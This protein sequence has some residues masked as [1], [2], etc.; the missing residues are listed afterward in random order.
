MRPVCIVTKH[1]SFTRIRSLH[2]PLANALRTRASLC[3]IVSLVAEEPEPDVM[4]RPPRDPKTALLDKFIAWRTFYVTIL[5]VVAMLGNEQWELSTGSSLPEARAVAMST[6]V[7]AQAL[8]ILSCRFVRH[9]SLTYRVFLGNPWLLAMILL[10][11]IIQVCSPTHTH[12]FAQLYPHRRLWSNQLQGQQFSIV[13]RQE[14]HAAGPR[15]TLTLHCQASMNCKSQLLL[16][17]NVSCVPSCSHPCPAA[18]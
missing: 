5:L 10:N 7:V 16:R 14:L 12:P 18:S 8:Y 15:A 1:D 4:R 2:Q 13:T 3:P 11:G 9:S 17:I 6:L